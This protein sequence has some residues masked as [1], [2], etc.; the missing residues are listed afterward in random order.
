MR[1]R[2]RLAPS[3]M[4][5]AISWWRAVARAS[6]SPETFAVAMSSSSPTAANSSRTVCRTSDDE[7]GAQRRQL[8]ARDTGW[9]R[10]SR[11]RASPRPRPCRPARSSIVCVRASG[12]PPPRSSRGCAAARDRRRPPADRPARASATGSTRATCRGSRSPP[13]S[14]RRSV[15][16]S[17]LMRS[18]WPIASRPAR[19]SADARARRSAPRPAARRAPRRPAANVRPSAGFDVEHVEE[20]GVHDRAG[21]RSPDDRRRRARTP[22]C[23]KPASAVKLC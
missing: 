4:R 2:P 6:S 18:V 15:C 19:R 16:G 5:T 11:A 9:S 7:I 22:A 1:I 23:R 13:A 21:R 10:G 3:A 12:A 8:N 14:R 17:S 20:V